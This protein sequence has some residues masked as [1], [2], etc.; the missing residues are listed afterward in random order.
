[1][2]KQHYLSVHPQANVTLAL[3]Q[4]LKVH[5]G[6]WFARCGEHEEIVEQKNQ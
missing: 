5:G 3:K 1:M 2:K 4:K 6:Q